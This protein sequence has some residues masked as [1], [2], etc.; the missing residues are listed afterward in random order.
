MMGMF[1]PPQR[2]VSIPAGS[3]PGSDE[4]TEYARRYGKFWY[5]PCGVGAPIRTLDFMMKTYDPHFKDYCIVRD[6]EGMTPYGKL[7]YSHMWM[8]NMM[9]RGLSYSVPA[10]DDPLIWRR[11]LTM[12]KK[13]LKE[14]LAH[15][16]VRYG[17]GKITLEETVDGILKLLAKDKVTLT[18]EFIKSYEEMKS[19]KEEYGARMKALLE[20]IRDFCE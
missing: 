13:T 10:P 20:K 8:L 17:E 3:L 6:I 12:K 5:G 1:L 7:L 15:I 14:E 4:L 9:T 18:D 16:R 2:Q 11:L 19:A